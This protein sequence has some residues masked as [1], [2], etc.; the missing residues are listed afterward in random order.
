[1]A[2]LP[3]GPSVVFTARATLSAPLS[4][5]SLAESSNVS[6]LA[7]G[8]SSSCSEFAKLDT[9]TKGEKLIPVGPRAKAGHPLQACSGGWIAD[10]QPAV[11]LHRRWAAMKNTAKSGPYGTE[12]AALN[13]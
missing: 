2:V 12:T 1:M 10:D 4:S 11:S 7:I 13:P 8:A 9:A 3:L 5:F 6:S